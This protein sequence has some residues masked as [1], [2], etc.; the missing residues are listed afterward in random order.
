VA[1]LADRLVVG[2]RSGVTALDRFRYRGRGND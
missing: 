1:D 2:L